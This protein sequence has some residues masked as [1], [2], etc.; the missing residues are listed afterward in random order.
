MGAARWGKAS[1]AGMRQCK[2]LRR[3]RAW[4]A[5]KEPVREAENNMMRLES[6]RARVCT[7]FV[8]LGL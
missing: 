8:I 7:G 3:E 6:N 2:G 4:P 5:G 1:Q